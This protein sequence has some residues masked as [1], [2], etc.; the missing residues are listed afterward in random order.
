M[1]SHFP[2]PQESKAIVSTLGLDPSDLK[3]IACAT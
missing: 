3:Q 1:N 2:L